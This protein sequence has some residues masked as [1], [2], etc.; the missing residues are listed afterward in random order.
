MS[1]REQM[2]ADLDLF[3]DTS[4]L[5]VELDFNGVP[6]PAVP[7]RSYQAQAGQEQSPEHGVFVQRVSYQIREQDLDPEPVIGEE[8]TLDGQYWIVEEIGPRDFA[9]VI[10]FSRELS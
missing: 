7:A 8:V 6:I 9:R 1:L 4:E 10:T 3:F 2:Q 5:A